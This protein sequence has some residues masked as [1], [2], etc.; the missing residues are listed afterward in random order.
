MR[1]RTKDKEQKQRRVW[2]NE[3]RKRGEK[4]EREEGMERK[5]RKG[6]RRE[7]EERQ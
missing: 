7:G 4:E 6:R 3:G 5:V 1:K 2:R